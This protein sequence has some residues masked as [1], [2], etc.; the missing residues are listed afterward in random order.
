MAK[1]PVQHPFGPGRSAPQ[2]AARRRSP[3]PAAGYAGP[4]RPV[5]IGQPCG[6]AEAQAATMGKRRAVMAGSA[7]GRRPN[8]GQQHDRGP[9]AVSDERGR[10]RLGRGG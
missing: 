4:K 9:L 2:D 6:R 3:D 5:R 1:F 7:Q 10:F 8:N